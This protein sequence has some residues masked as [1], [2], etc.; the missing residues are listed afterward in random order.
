[1]ALANFSDLPVER[2]TSPGG[3][4]RVSVIICTRNR[5]DSA[6]LTLETVL[7]NSHPSFELILVD[8]STSPETHRAVARFGDDPRFIYL[9]TTTRGLGRARNIGL[10]AA[11][12]EIVAF[13]DDDCSVPPNW[14][15]VI[16]A[17]FHRNPRIGVVFCNVKAG[18]FDASQGFIPAY[19]RQDSKLVQSMWDKCAARGIG[20]GIA[21]RRAA[22]E[23]LGGFDE[24]L[25]AGGYFPSCEDGDMAVR[26]ILKGWWVYETA[27]VAV[28]HYG[29]RTWQQGK[30]LTQR[31][32]VGIGAAYAKPLK[33]G[34]WSAAILVGYELLVAI[35]KPLESLVRRGRPQGAGQA[36]YF[37][38]G[39]IQ[40]LRTPVDRQRILFRLGKT[41]AHEAK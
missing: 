37:V 2:S 20:A 19:E 38:Q 32:W 28:I 14:L 34:H 10:A 9:P 18:P 8:Q 23:A 5:G 21:V 11:R 13:T 4:P 16:E 12:G 24:E 26:A 40:G 29:F 39:F 7:A 25:G 35:R 3:P 17:T 27:E 22:A 41:M 15:A 6:V 33:C 1:M 36:A 31:D 30:D